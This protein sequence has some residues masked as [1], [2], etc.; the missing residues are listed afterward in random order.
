MSPDGRL[1]ISAGLDGTARLWDATAGSAPADEPFSALLHVLALAPD[2]RTAITVDMYGIGRIRSL[3]SESAETVFDTCQQM[4]MDG[5]V[6]RDGQRLAV[7]DSRGALVVWDVQDL[8][9]LIG[10]HPHDRAATCQFIGGRTAVSGSV[11]GSV[12]AW[13][14]ETGDRLWTFGLREGLPVFAV[15]E[16]RGLIMVGSASGQVV[17]LEAASGHPVSHLHDG[18]DAVASCT[19]GHG[20]ILAA[21]TAAGDVLMWVLR[22]RALVG[23][24]GGSPGRHEGRVLH[25]AAGTPEH[26]IISGSADH[27]VGL[28][29]AEAGAEVTWLNGHDAPV[30]QVLNGP[31]NGLIMSAGDDRT[32]RAWAAAGAPVALLPIEGHGQL[33]TTGPDGELIVCGDSGGFTYLARLRGTT[34]TTSAEAGGAVG[35][36][37]S[38]G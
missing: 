21:G 26:P 11:D 27:R 19:F 17:L 20:G 34:T 38:G 13:N 14:V 23:R 32:L 12:I 18:S 5:A 30:R 24:R 6:S 33:L 8:P 37:S 22:D 29:P 16:R 36:F 3:N 28:W 10:T 25:L 2:G 1:A 9:R 35:Q 7:V 15:D 31:H 4:C